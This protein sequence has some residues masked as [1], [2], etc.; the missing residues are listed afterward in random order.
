MKNY[1][2]GVRE[3][4]P[5]YEIGRRIYAVRTKQYYMFQQTCPVCDGTKKITYRGYEMECPYCVR[6]GARDGSVASAI[7]IRTFKVEEFIVRSVEICGPDTKSAYE[8]RNKDDIFNVPKINKV[9]MFTRRDNGYNGVEEITVQQGSYL[10]P[11]DEVVRNALQIEAMA[12]TSRAKAAAA[13]K[14]L[15]EMEKQR[16]AEFNEKFGCSYE[17]PE[18]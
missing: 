8:P 18:E 15:V 2:I 9:T 4:P 11:T 12:F 1:T 17:Y 6:R 14:I 13:K 16:L 7:R 5:V 10:D 3:L